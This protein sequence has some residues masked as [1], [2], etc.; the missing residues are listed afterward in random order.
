MSFLKMVSDRIGGIVSIRKISRD[1]QRYSSVKKVSYELNKFSSVAA[2]PDWVFAAY[3]DG[4]Y[5]RALL[6][7]EG[8]P[9]HSQDYF[10]LKGIVLNKMGK[11]EE[12]ERLLRAGIEAVCED[13]K[14]L[15]LIYDTLGWAL[16]EQRRFED[17]VLLFEE[18]I[19][20]GEERSAGHRAI[21]WVLL[22]SGVDPAK[23]LSKAQVA[24][25]I[26][27]SDS[28]ANQDPAKMD[29]CDAVSTLA[30]AAAV[31]SKDEWEVGKLERETSA[32]CDPR[33]MPALALMHYNMGR[34]FSE[35]GNVQK[36]AS[37]LEK[38]LAAD[39][40]GDWGRRAKAELAKLLE[41]AKV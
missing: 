13:E 29:L 16:V 39:P 41:E 9:H 27:F 17:A 7:C 2:N 3:R 30:W 18:S 25:R 21:A 4:D 34:A 14:R 19:R 40:D 15:I 6:M 23:A 31:N 12:S 1:M 20:F 26:A 24:A 32:L 33:N 37:H 8:L 36:G 5:E 11:L 38:S 28:V 35:L 22:L 10:Y